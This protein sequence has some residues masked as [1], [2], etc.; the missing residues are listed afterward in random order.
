MQ[1]ITT[2]GLDIAK[3]VFQVH[4]VD[5]AGNV[6]VRRQLKCRYQGAPKKRALTRSLRDLG[7]SQGMAVQRAL[8]LL[9]RGSTS[10]PCASGLF[11]TGSG[12]REFVLLLIRLPPSGIRLPRSRPRTVAATRMTPKPFSRH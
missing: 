12:R 1:A 7:G 4:G 10:L 6:V 11:S 5:A 2:I 3:F 8:A 9:A